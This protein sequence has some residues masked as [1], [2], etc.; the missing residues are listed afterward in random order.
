MPKEVVT[1][2][3]TY[4]ESGTFARG[5]EQLSGMASIA[6]FGNTNQP[7]EVMVRSSH[8][9][10]PMPDIIREDTAF[11]DRIH[12]Y[13]PGWEIPKMQVS[14][15]TKGYGFVVDYLAEA[16]REMRRRNYTEIIDRDFGLGPQPFASDTA[17]T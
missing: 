6:M 10:S 4:C 12:F 9:F 1:T 16:L 2:L 3:K 17:L 8:L 7:V 15:F 14:M 5:K 13:V 11:L